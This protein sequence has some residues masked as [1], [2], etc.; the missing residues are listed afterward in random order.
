MLPRG[1]AYRAAPT[2][3]LRLTMLFALPHGL[4]AR[5]FRG[6]FDGAADQG[7]SGKPRHAVCDRHFNGR[8]DLAD[9]STVPCLRSDIALAGTAPPPPEPRAAPQTA[10]RPTRR[11]SS[12]LLMSIS[13]RRQIRAPDG[14]ALLLLSCR[15]PRDELLPR[16]PLPSPSRLSSRLS[17][18]ALD[19]S[20]GAD[21]IGER[22]ENRHVHRPLDRM[23]ESYRHAARGF[24]RTT[25]S[26]VTFNADAGAAGSTVA[27]A[28]PQV[29]IRHYCMAT[30]DPQLRRKRQPRHSFF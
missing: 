30:V 10:P 14:Y 27:Y 2:Q 25:R 13:N 1:L 17:T 29:Y 4:A 15:S 16:R 21:R 23:Y 12:R 28:A 7:F 5:G 19:H 6:G 18:R 22:K 20:T 8:F 24:D 11:F 26:P 9:A 3:S